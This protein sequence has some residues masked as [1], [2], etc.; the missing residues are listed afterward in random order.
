M[1]QRV[2]VVIAASFLLSGCAAI[3]QSGHV[4]AA[5]RTSPLDFVCVKTTYW[6]P[7]KSVRR[8]DI[9]FLPGWRSLLG[10]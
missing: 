7:C 9:R 5:A 10:E 8:N 3:P 6:E 1:S 4:K 2:K